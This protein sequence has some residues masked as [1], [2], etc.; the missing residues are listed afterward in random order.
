MLLL[1]IE[2][3]S[4]LDFIINFEGNN[5]IS[6]DEYY[7]YLTTNPVELGRVYSV[8]FLNNDNAVVF[9]IH[10][11]TLAFKLSMFRKEIIIAFSMHHPGIKENERVAL[12]AGIFYQDKMFH[13]EILFSHPGEILKNDGEYTEH[14]LKFCPETNDFVLGIKDEKSYPVI[15]EL[16]ED[17]IL[18]RSELKST[19]K[20][21]KRIRIDY[22]NLIQS[23]IIGLN[24]QPF[25]KRNKLTDTDFYFEN[26]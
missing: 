6:S 12:V 14:L 5:S 10:N 26:Y 23:V 9:D 24:K 19:T 3:K 22:I 1:P 17:F 7:Y 25:L 21:S 2:D 11:K 16:N 4:F 20:N 15:V 13:R 18:N 8:S